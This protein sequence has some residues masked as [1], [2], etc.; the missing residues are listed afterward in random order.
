M[1]TE[2]VELVAAG[3]ERLV[4]DSLAADLIELEKQYVYSNIWLNRMAM[5]LM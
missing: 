4:N 2:R 1:V 3:C 5:L